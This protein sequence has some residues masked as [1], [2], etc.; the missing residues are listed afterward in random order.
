MFEY[1]GYVV[2]SHFAE[3]D[4]YVNSPSSNISQKHQLMGIKRGRN[5]HNETLRLSLLKNS[6]SS[7]S[8]WQQLYVPSFVKTGGFGGPL[9]LG[10]SSMRMAQER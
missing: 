9:L 7:L 2:S 6:L 10:S 1:E 8:S 3:S 5:L 4:Q